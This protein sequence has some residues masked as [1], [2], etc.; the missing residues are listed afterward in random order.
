MIL[1]LEPPQIT[2]NKPRVA[3]FPASPEE[4]GGPIPSRPNDEILLTCRAAIGKPTP[5]VKWYKQ[6]RNVTT[7][8]RISILSDGT[9]RL[10]NVQLDDEDNYTCT[11]TNIVGTASSVIWL[12]VNGENSQCLVSA[13][14]V[15]HPVCVEFENHWVV[16]AGN[17][18]RTCGRGELCT[19]LL[20]QHQSNF[21]VWMSGSR[22]VSS[23]CRR[24][25]D[26]QLM[27]N[28]DCLGQR[29]PTSV[30]ERCGEIPCPGRLPSIGCSSPR[31]VS[32]IDLSSS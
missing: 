3:G 11:A 28:E 17:C 15:Y 27:S 2:D 30:R 8:D 19:P 18:S 22:V 4:P 16:V 7:S 14:T 21:N 24:K 5:D 6:G 13:Y 26:D 12:A 1:L 10:S 31:R 25:S 9:L 23:Q 20:Q 29:R 32:K